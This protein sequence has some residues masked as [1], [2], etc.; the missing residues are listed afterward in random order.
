M[1]R[2]RTA[3]LLAVLIGLVIW[4]PPALRPA[5]RD[6]NA[7]LA[8]P[9]SLDAAAVFQVGTWVLSG[10]VVA[11]LMVVRLLRQEPSFLIVPASVPAWSLYLLL[12]C[13]GA[14]SVLWSSAP[15]Y[16]A[17]FAVQVVI[18][19]LLA[20]AYLQIARDPLRDVLRTV[21]VTH[22]AWMCLT[23]VLFLVN[24]SLVAAPTGTDYLRLHGGILGG[25]GLPALVT[26]LFM[27]STALTSDSP[28]MRAWAWAGYLLSWGALLA[29][30]TRATIALALI[31]AAI[32]STVAARRS[33]QIALLVAGVG[34]L[35]AIRPPAWLAELG[36]LALRDGQGL[37]T[38]S[39][40]SV[41]F[42][43]LMGV[44]QAAPFFGHGFAAGT[45][46]ALV[47]YYAETGLNFGAGH[48]VM[49]TILVD[50]GIVGLA[51][52]VGA[53]LAA[54]FPVFRLWTR[55]NSSPQHRLRRAQITCLLAM[56]TMMGLT[57]QGIAK[58]SMVF[59]IVVLATRLLEQ[60]TTRPR[61]A[62]RSA[63]TIL[64]PYS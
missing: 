47:D 46:A 60:E 37:S 56:V 6:L 55:L 43:Y 4:G 20:A 35:L 34:A 13:V 25:Y 29:S 3:A 61:L 64:V 12:G 26:G 11:A 49:S 24:P 17:Y 52:V 8:S 1:T 15:T 16:T 48:D 39:G 63:T 14:A 54:W 30:Q 28:R 22:F 32:L 5:A 38:L 53:V 57:T 18:V 40:R 59:V 58:A 9:L 44:W 36:D 50:L 31:F 45:R 10:S 2:G 21:F 51:L 19:C 7:A 33:V 42:E 41:V 23:L 62:D 27:L